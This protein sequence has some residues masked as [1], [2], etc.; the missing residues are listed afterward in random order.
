VCVCVCVCVCV[1]GW[2]SVVPT[3]PERSIILT[4]NVYPHVD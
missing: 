4:I 2:T 3:G 1:W